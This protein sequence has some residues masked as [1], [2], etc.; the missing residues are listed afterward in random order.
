MSRWKLLDTWDKDIAGLSEKEL[1]E[2][3]KLAKGYESRSLRPGIGRNPKAGRMWREKRE[4][5][6]A[7]IEHRG[8]AD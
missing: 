3:L 2:R 1:R 8:N 7:E 4:A 6:E 5:V